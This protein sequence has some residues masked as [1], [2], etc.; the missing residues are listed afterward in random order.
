MLRPKADDQ[1]PKVKQ[2]VGKK[3]AMFS[4]KEVLKFNLT[5][6][7]L[8]TYPTRVPHVL[9]F[10]QQKMNCLSHEKKLKPFK[11]LNKNYISYL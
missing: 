2:R 1:L 11:S 8:S 7:S 9:R 3:E 6:E 10:C 4:L 5:R